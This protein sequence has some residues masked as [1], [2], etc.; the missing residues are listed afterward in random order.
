MDAS[1]S[2]NRPSRQQLSIVVDAGSKAI[3][4]GLDEARKIAE[5]YTPVITHTAED[6]SKG[7]KETVVNVC[8]LLPPDMN[9]TSNLSPDEV[10]ITQ[11]WRRAL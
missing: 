1:P 5:R 11:V 4:S 3:K 10:S 8:S 9:L 6:F 7:A 2:F